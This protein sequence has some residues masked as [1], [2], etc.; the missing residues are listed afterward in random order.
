M[1]VQ[2]TTIFNTSLT[3]FDTYQGQS[4]DKYSLQITLDT[5]NADMLD[6]AGVKVKEYEGEPI[7]KFT[8][9]YDIPVFTG[10]NERWRCS[11]LRKGIARLTVKRSCAVLRSAV[12]IVFCCGRRLL[13][14]IRCS[15]PML[16]RFHQITAWS[17]ARR[18]NWLSMPL[19][20]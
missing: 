5:F 7:R 20:G 15:A 4:T 17:R 9:R 19:M 1:L 10:K 8:S 2:G 16:F 6:K 13:A 3:Q 11:V 12:S 18:L 14:Q